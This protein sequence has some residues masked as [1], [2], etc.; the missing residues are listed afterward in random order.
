MKKLTLILV[1]I[2][3]LFAG[4][5]YA[6]LISTSAS[7]N[8]FGDDYSYT[9]TI[10]DNGNEFDGLFSATLI[11][12]SYSSAPGALIDALAFNTLDP[13]QTLGTDFTI[14]NI[15]PIWTFSQ[16]PSGVNFDYVGDRTNPDN[17]LGVGYSL[18]FDMTFI[19]DYKLNGF[20]I[21]TGSET[22]SGG[23]LGGGDDYGQV[24]VSFQRLGLLDD[25]AGV[26]DFNED[27]DGSDLLASNWESTPVPEPATMLLLGVGLVGLAGASRKKSFK[28]S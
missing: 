8:L 17:R 6:D 18:T 12:T 2:S 25:N 14:E 4:S 7:G 23:G 20:S 13:D 5:A 21:F 9:F 27:G 26:A 28:K 22:S 16:S 10:S 19:T 3:F 1:A 11:N 24:G 15:S